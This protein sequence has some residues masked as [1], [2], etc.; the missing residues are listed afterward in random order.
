MHFWPFCPFNKLWD[1][2]QIL[3]SQN[4]DS[5][6][7][8]LSSID[9]VG[10]I[11][12]NNCEG[13]WGYPP[14]SKGLIR[15]AT[16]LSMW[17]WQCRVTMGIKRCLSGCG[18]WGRWGSEWGLTMRLKHEVSAAG[19]TVMKCFNPKYFTRWARVICTLQ[20]QLWSGS[21]QP[22]ILCVFVLLQMHLVSVCSLCSRCISEWSWSDLCI[23]I[24][25]DMRSSHCEHQSVAVLVLREVYA[26]QCSQTFRFSWCMYRI[27]FYELFSCPLF[28]LPCPFSTY[29]NSS[30]R[31]A[32]WSGLS[33]VRLL[34]TARAASLICTCVVIV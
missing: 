15:V 26:T 5:V 22:C 30:S 34:V 4:T 25:Q 10:A 2:K 13:F 17:W 7:T 32:S 28:F 8:T 3:G 6:E 18:Q 12:N 33:G 19:N 1:L 20:T 14:I 16:H 21:I 9:T 11:W 24:Y 31:S 29:W 23:L 27:Q